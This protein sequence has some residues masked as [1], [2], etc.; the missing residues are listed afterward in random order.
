MKTLAST[1]DLSSSPECLRGWVSRWTQLQE[2]FLWLGHDLDLL[3]NQAH[4][5]CLLFSVLPLLEVEIVVLSKEEGA[6]RTGSKTE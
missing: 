2:Q 4:F 3:E 6:G 1:S 5:C